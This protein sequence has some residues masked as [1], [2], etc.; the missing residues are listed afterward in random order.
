MIAS[1]AMMVTL[2]FGSRHPG[3]GAWHPIAAGFCALL[4]LRKR[5]PMVAFLGVRW[6]WPRFRMTKLMDRLY[7]YPIGVGEHCFLRGVAVADRKTA[8][9]QPMPRISSMSSY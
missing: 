7:V 5:F 4:S 1:S 3:H 9:R 8:M 6:M 2:F